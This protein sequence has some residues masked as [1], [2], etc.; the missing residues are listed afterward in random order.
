MAKYLHTQQS[1][2]GSVALGLTRRTAISLVV[3]LVA[4]GV[5]LSLSSLPKLSTTAWLLEHLRS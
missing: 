4:V 3:L 5:G 1:S 2:E